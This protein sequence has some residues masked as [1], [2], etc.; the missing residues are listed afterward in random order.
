MTITPVEKPLTSKAEIALPIK[1][2]LAIRV[3]RV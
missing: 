2:C 3:V 1:P